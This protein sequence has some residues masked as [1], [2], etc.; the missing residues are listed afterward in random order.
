MPAGVQGFLR[1]GCVC[2]CKGSLRS[3]ALPV[4][5]PPPPSCVFLSSAP[6]VPGLIAAVNR[7][8]FSLLLKLPLPASLPS[9]AQ[10]IANAPAVGLCCFVSWAAPAALALVWQH[11][12]LWKHS[13][14]WLGPGL[15]PWRCQPLSPQGRSRRS[16]VSG[17]WQHEAAAQGGVCRLQRLGLLPL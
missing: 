6:S 2:S 3:C 5:S 14:L 13:M 12:S 10:V 4:T 15:Q 17:G 16:C 7:S 9:C 11:R 1:C 8:F